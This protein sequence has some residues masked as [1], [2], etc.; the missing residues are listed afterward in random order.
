LDTLRSACKQK[1]QAAS[2]WAAR[3][4]ATKLSP[5]EI[6]KAYFLFPLYIYKIYKL[7]KN[8]KTG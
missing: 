3:K 2:K 1:L 8:R 5:K 4:K 7:L 6:I